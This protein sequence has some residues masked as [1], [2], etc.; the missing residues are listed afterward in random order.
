MP[1][2]GADLP[3]YVQVKNWIRA[4]IESGELRPNEALPG[5]RELVARL[6]LSRTTVRQALSDLVA[7]GVLYRHHGK[8]TF[9]AP[10]K[11]EQNLT[12]LTGFAEEL[13]R[14]EYSPTIE[15]L[16]QEIHYAPPGIAATL[17]I[18]AGEPV[19]FIAR[20]IL[21][22]GEP[23]FVDRIYLVHS[24]G[25]L[26]LQSNLASESIYKLIE[27]LGYPIREGLQTIGAIAMKPNDAQLLHVDPFSPAL[28][29]QRV[30][31]IEEDAPIEYSEAV[32]R[33]DR[34]QYQTRLTRHRGGGIE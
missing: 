29:L 22:D 34:F 2:R 33:A 24:I 17:K 8:G 26:V 15:V 16:A 12:W 7:E 9:V 19:A 14:L 11:Y 1:I 28:F 13:R 27:R 10:R 31:F 5:E 21:T 30:T 4:R 23:L 32:Y 20:R 3:L 18:E 25:E 6:G